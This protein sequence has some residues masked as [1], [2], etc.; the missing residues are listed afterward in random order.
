MKSY[1]VLLKIVTAIVSAVKKRVK[2]IFGVAAIVTVTF[3]I[4]LFLNHIFIGN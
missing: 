3:L 2:M 4:A 1:I